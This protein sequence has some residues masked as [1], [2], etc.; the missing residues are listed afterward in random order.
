M[1]G[2][3]LVQQV[4][5]LDKCCHCQNLSFCS[6]NSLNK[7]TWRSFLWFG[8]MRACHRRKT[9]E[10]IERKDHAKVV[11]YMMNKKCRSGDF[12]QC[13]LLRATYLSTEPSHQ[14]PKLYIRQQRALIVVQTG[15]IWKKNAIPLI[16]L[17]ELWFSL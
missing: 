9:E 1:R 8:E 10:A 13:F 2:T 17:E 6:K 14:N 4:L 16:K 7:N 12:N 15:Y 5:S 11:R 3:G